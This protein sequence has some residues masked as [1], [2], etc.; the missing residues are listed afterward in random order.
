VWFGVPLR[1][2]PLVLLLGTGLFLTSS[3][4]MG[5]F[6]STISSTQQQAQITTFFFTLPA[7]TLSGFAFPIES[8]PE[9]VQTIT[10][11]IPLRY[12]LIVIRG[13]FLKANGL[14]ILWPQM[15]AMAAMGGLMILLSSLRFR[16]RLK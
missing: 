11:G 15:A 13:V 14:G 8:M 1:G 3:V 4:S 12:F 5:L 16:K 7:F 9:W 6:I 10:Y 2:N